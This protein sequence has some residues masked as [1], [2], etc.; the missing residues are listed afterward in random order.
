MHGDFHRP[1]II[2]FPTLIELSSIPM[3][4]SPSITS[5]QINII[6]FTDD[7]QDY[8]KFEYALSAYSYSRFFICTRG[9][10]TLTADN[11]TYT[12][13]ER[14]ACNIFIYQN[15][16]HPKCSP[17]SEGYL[18]VW[19]DVIDVSIRGH[20]PSPDLIKKVFF[21]PCFTLKEGHM[22]DL[23]QMLKLMGRVASRPQTKYNIEIL[24]HITAAMICEVLSHYEEEVVYDPSKFT[25][26]EVYYAD[27]LELIFNH[28]HEEH[29]VDFYARKLC[30]TSRYLNSI[31]KEY[32]GETAAKSIS[33]LLHSTAK[34]YLT[35]S[36]LSIQ[37]IADALHFANPSFFSQFF[38]RMEG[39]T[40]SEFRSRHFR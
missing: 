2:Y 39:C 12:L 24:Q 18:F 26:K 32:C 30:I 20:Y 14:D 35:G 21:Y 33:G 40:P 5:R 31:C 28:Y 10:I 19:N 13:H 16:Q 3:A 25:R 6:H 7:V 9:T 17:G 23:I 15:I 11:T 4:H 34:M 29:T 1:F 22:E 8:S 38:R 36:N 37:Q 27:F